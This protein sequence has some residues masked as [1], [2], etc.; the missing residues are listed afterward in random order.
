M[1][2][3]MKKKIIDKTTV[4]IQVNIYLLAEKK[5]DVPP[6]FNHKISFGYYYSY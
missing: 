6:I 2:R 4:R 5:V 3:V 1:L